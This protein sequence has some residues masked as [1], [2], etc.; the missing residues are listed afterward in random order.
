MPHLR[1]LRPS[2]AVLALLLVLLAPGALAA[3]L[4]PH[5][6]WST[7]ET[8]NFR[9]HFHEGVEE[10]AR[11]A[12]ARAEVAH[13]ELSAAL[14]RAPAGRVDLVVTD[15]VD[16]TNGY[17]TPF[18]SNRIVIYAH[19]PVGEQGLGFFDDWLELVITHELVHIFHLDYAR[20][21]PAVARRV[22]GRNPLGF[23]NIFVPGWTTEGLA[24][25]LES[26]L[27]GAGRVRGTTFDMML[28]TA[29]LED[30]FF[31]I[32]RATGNPSRWPGG[33]TRYLYGALFV[34]WLAER[35]GA[36]RVGDWVRRVGGSVVP[37]T[38]DRHAR[39][40]FGISFTRA[41][42]EWQTELAAR[43]RPLAD[44]LRAAGLTEAQL[45]TRPGREA[46]HPRWSPDGAWIS[47]A[48]ST[49]REAASTRLVRPD[50]GEVEVLAR[51]STLEP[52]SWLPDGRGLVTSQLERRGPYRIHADLYRV[53]VPG[54]DV[55]PL[56]RAARLL[57]PD[58]SR[59]GRSVVATR[60][61]GG[62]TALVRVDLATG[63]V[64]EL[65]A[66]SLDV[67]WSLPRWSP[68]GA[69]IAVA[70]WRQGGRQ[71]VVVLDSAGRVLAEA[72]D[73]RAVDGAPAWT[74]DGRWVLFSSD[75]T[76][77][78]NLYAW[79]PASGALRQ[80]TNVLTGAFQPDV[81]PDG[82][83]VAFVLYRADGY[84]IARIPFDPAGWRPAP[85]VRA[86]VRVEP[87]SLPAPYAGP[88]RPYSP[89]R[90]LVPRA[91]SPALVTDDALGVG[92]GA[93]I[94][95]EDVIG[96][97]AY[98]V[99]ALVY[100]D[101]GRSDLSAGYVYRGLGNPV[102]SASAYQD[103]D[104]VLDATTARS[105]LLERDRVAALGAS[106]TRPRWHSTTW[107]S[108][109]ASVRDRRRAWD[110][111]ARAGDPRFRLAFPT[112]VGGAATVGVSTLQGYALSIS[113]ERGVYATLTGEGRRY[114]E[115]FAGEDEAQGYER[116][117]AR[118][119]GFHP[120][121][122]PG[123]ARHVLGVRAS[124]AGEHGRRAPGLEVGGTDGSSVAL[125]PGAA[126]GPGD[127]VD[128][129]VRGYP[130]GAQLGD[131][132]FSASAEYRFPL[133]LVE[134]G[135]RVLP[136][137][138]DRLWGAAFV[139][140]GAAWC[141]ET[142]VAGTVGEPRSARPLWSAGAELATELQL[143]YAAALTVRG[144]VAMP[145]SR[146]EFNQGVFARPGAK[147]YVRFGRSF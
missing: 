83:T 57:E 29:V 88:A 56:T 99:S 9:V 42:G 68:D 3:Q 26:R 75:R 40:V 134:R 139:D 55:E 87:E 73:D 146:V 35:Y 78:A 61:G 22:L 141:V 64:R 66:P 33:N 53:S 142:C 145:F 121:A 58:V 27:T 130:A 44:S 19:P 101:G 138:L 38:L 96:R 49:G 48:A 115:P 100:S 2:F 79:E 89:W 120:L 106:L 81:S 32:D 91:W 14:V 124:V 92:V 46:F 51:R 144:G 36:E 69:R 13:A 135:R 98:G 127:D 70:R 12:A 93:A 52:A 109:S 50:G 84:H 117:T 71:D 4:P 143:G 90:S 119:R 111:P 76:G 126:V 95:Q 132:A 7:L 72:T 1:A 23:P 60:A 37:Y 129:P 125:A 28:R 5:V 20:G 118:A 17:A 133:M 34:D 8:P 86:E 43:Y 24:T 85:P 39:A 54:G 113:P 107:V 63:A 45:L 74:P 47:Y 21:L 105:A 108:A 147:L 10:L 62:T 102:L 137:F 31:S 16:F 6:R 122:L 97:H 128:F 80:V 140:A 15:N 67:H 94:G 112:D 30:E 110:D 123:F 59:D 65:V 136:V 103:W 77:I 18:P 11:R 104:V 116:L 82:R 114:T 25:H 131:R 41:W